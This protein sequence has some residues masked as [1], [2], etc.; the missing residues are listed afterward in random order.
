MNEDNIN[1][2]CPSEAMRHELVNLL[3]YADFAGIDAEKI[4]EK[5]KTDGTLP[6]GNRKEGKDALKK[7]KSEILSTLF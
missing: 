5:M 2:F 1:L 7:L 4:M 6:V 3:K